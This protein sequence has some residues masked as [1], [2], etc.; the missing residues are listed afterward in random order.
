MNVNAMKLNV[1]LFIKTNLSRTQSYFKDTYFNSILLILLSLYIIFSSLSYPSL[2]TPDDF[3]FYLKTA[4]NLWDYNFVTFDGINPT[5][6]VHPFYFL[7]ISIVYFFLDLLGFDDSKFSFIVF[8][9]IYCTFIYWFCCQLVHKNKALL[10]YASLLICSFF[11]ESTLLGLL[12]C[13]LYTKKNPLLIFLIIFIRIDSI[14]ILAPLILYEFLNN[15]QLF[16][17]YITFTFMAVL[18]TFSFNY[19]L[20]DSFVSISSYSKINSNFSIFD[21]LSFNFSSELLISKLLI[22]ST[23]IYFSTKILIYDKKWEAFAIL[24]GLVIFVLMHLCFSMFRS[25]YLAPL[26]IF[27]IF[28]M[29]N[30]INFFQLLKSKA[31]FGIYL[32]TIFYIGFYATHDFIIYKKDREISSDYISKVKNYRELVGFKVDQSGFTSYF[33]N[34]KIVNGDGLINSF[35]FFKYKQKDLMEY[36]AKYGYPDYILK[37]SFGEVKEELNFHGERY[38]HTWSSKE[39]KMMNYII[40]EKC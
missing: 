30:N 5:N 35:E 4:S 23:L 36:F 1:S 24:A 28:I 3:F 40:H 13:L 27:C 29:L 26:L 19:L 25:W 9:V 31:Y 34:G 14:V 2:I 32:L 15:R 21:K 10:L 11:M 18:C 16:Y 8:S 38:C 22:T 39:G 17:K 37:S 33:S 12:L 20:D 7:L 6:G